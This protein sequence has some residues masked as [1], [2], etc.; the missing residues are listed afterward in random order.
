[1]KVRPIPFSDPMVRAILAGT[2]TH[3]RRVVKAGAAPDGIWGHCQGVGMGRVYRLDEPPPAG[4]QPWWKRGG[5]NGAADRC[6]YGVPG[7][8]LWVRE[9][10]AAPHSCDHLKP[11]EISESTP[12]HYLASEERGGLLWR[13]PLFIPRWASRLLLEVTAVRVERLQDI[14][15]E[16]A[17]AEGVAAEPFT[18]EDI[19][20]MPAGSDA[21]RLGEALGP[22]EFTAK[23][24]FAQGWDGLNAKR[25]Y[26]WAANPWV[27]VIGFQRLAQAAQ[28]AA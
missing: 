2:K 9:A 21:R 18:A 4:A 27:W 12:I 11:R 6:P 1:M 24:S 3:T 17:R 8:R 13:N 5:V 15:E 23:L 25:G 26:G 10:W 20:A 14:S 28:G 22:G 7:D 19:A 16:D